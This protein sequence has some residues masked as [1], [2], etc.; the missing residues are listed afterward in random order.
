MPGLAANFQIF[1]YISLPQDRFERHYLEWLLP[2]SMDESIE[3]Y[4]K[5]M[6]EFVN[7]ENVIL[8]GVSFGGVMV[9]EMAKIIKPTKIVIISSIKSNKELSKRLRFIKGTKSYKLFPEN[10]ITALENFIHGI[11][12]KKTQKRL[13]HYK[14]YLSMR[15][16]LYLKWAIYNVLHWQQ[17]YTTQNVLHI[18][19][20]S[21]HIFPIKYINNCITIKNGEH[22]MIINKAKEI[23]RI[24]TQQL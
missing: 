21:D 23:S 8:I 24:L 7:E 13:E 17:G 22:I 12:G 19:G 6:C 16:P 18:H 14:I 9:Q 4:A 2:E 1:K 11:T 10:S 5:R 3:N 15:D 20:S